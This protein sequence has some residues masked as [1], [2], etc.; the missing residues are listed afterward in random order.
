MWNKLSMKDKVNYIKIAVRNG[1]TKLSD[2]QNI[3]NQY[4]D[5]GEIQLPELVVTPRMNYTTEP[6]ISS[7]HNT[8]D[9]LFGKTEYTYGGGGFLNI[10]EGTRMVS[11]Y[12]VED[13]ETGDLY[14]L[15]GNKMI[16]VSSLEE[17]G[18]HA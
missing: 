11:N 16:G 13:E 18:G 10:P 9:K 15:D 4:A 8:T 14:Y 3:Y 2:I 12:V 5:E 1:I 7:V 6:T 17:G